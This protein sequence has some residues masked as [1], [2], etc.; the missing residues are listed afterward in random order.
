MVLSSSVVCVD[1][2]VTDGVSV[3]V[4]LGTTVVK[5]DVGLTVVVEDIGE[6]RLV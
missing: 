1:F 6:D 4:V 3:N 5:M 2:V